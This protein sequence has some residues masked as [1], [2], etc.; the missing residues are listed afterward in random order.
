MNS[1]HHIRLLFKKYLANECSAPEAAE[2]IDIIQSGENKELIESLISQHF[3]NYAADELLYKAASEQLFKKLDLSTGNG[4]ILIEPR[5]KPIY[6]KI[7]AAIVVMLAAYTAFYFLKPAS[8]SRST[9]ITA[10]QD[11]VLPGGNKATLVLSDG[12][13]VELNNLQVGGIAEDKGVVIKK[14][15]DGQLA[16]YTSHNSKPSGLNTVKTPKG[17]QYQV[18]LPDGSKVW[19]NAASSITYPAVF[20][21]LERRVTLTGEG[22]FEIVAMMKN[23]KKVP[24]IV[25]SGKQKIEV[26]GTRF[27]VNAYDDETGIKTT[28]IE[29][30]VKVVTENETVIL[31]PSQE[32][33][34]RSEG[35]ST[36]KVDVEPVIDWKNGDF[37]FADEDIKSIMRKI[38]RWYNVELV[39][40]SEIPNENLSGQISR[41]RNLSEVLRMLELSGDTKFR[42]E[43]STIYISHSKK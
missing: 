22:Y 2:L 18:I 8:A 30:K 7:A 39:Y 43:N 31:K 24:F 34:L 23:N 20:N 10:P 28:L 41:S 17:G 25:E 21:A 9:V 27:N 11:D 6:L 3:G 33:N 4:A 12:Q 37:I 13:Q 42:I 19:L 14:P 26:L 5:R 15:A 40:E 36:K 1:E 38:G 35:I 29:G 32:F 16:Y